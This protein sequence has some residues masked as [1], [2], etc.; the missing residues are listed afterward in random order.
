LTGVTPDDNFLVRDSANITDFYNLN[1]LRPVP[2]RYDAA[3]LRLV[4]A[5]VV[6]PA[7]LPVPPD[8]FDPLKETFVPVVLH[9]WHDD[10]ATLTAPNSHRVVRGSR[11]H[12][13]ANS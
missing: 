12:I 6:I 4:S 13:L 3:K 5:T 2:R 1:S 10:G 9:G 8:G 7:W 11:A